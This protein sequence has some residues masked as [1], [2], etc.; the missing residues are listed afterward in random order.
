M[1]SPTLMWLSGRFTTADLTSSTS[2]GSQLPG[3]ARRLATSGSTLC[4]PCQANRADTRSLRQMLMADERHK[5]RR[6]R[7][8]GVAASALG[9]SPRVT[10]IDLRRLTTP[11]LTLR[12]RL[13]ALPHLAGRRRRRGGTTPL[14]RSVIR[15]GRLALCHP[16][17]SV[18]H[19]PKANLARY[20]CPEL[21]E[22]L[23]VQL[24]CRPP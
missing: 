9:L 23:F 21:R 10:A 13:A 20:G 15:R 17:S 16:G 3:P 14:G 11:E 4:L 24:Y 19:R 22:S 5:T 1:A 18:R 2:T 6:G 8:R 7:F 12:G